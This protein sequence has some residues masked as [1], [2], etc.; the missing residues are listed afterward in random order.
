MSTFATEAS[1]SGFHPVITR[2]THDGD[3]GYGWGGM[4][5]FALVIIFI[6][7]VLAF[8]WKGKEGEHRGNYLDGIYPALAMGQM[9]KGKDCDS[10]YWYDSAKEHG[11]IKKEIL[12]AAWAQSRE[13]DRY[14]FEQQKTMLLGF[15]DV[16]IQG[17]KN[18]A[19]I[20]GRIDALET[21]MKEDE[22]RRQGNRINYLE[23]VIALS[24]KPPAPAYF[25]QYPIPV[26]HNV[27]AETPSYHPSC[28]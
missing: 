11:D 13:S 12:G 24:P 19:S 23:T 28:A 9:N 6:I 17:L 20:E 25:P 27:Y 15:K 14:H 22:I 18:T 10:Q 7:L 3:K 5:V 16:E 21:R 26:Q 2:D 4:W 1:G 8:M